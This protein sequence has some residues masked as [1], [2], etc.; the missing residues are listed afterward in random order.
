MHIKPSIRMKW[1]S[2]GSQTE[3]KS[4]WSVMNRRV[5]Q[6][7]KNHKNHLNGFQFF[8]RYFINIW[9]C[10]QSYTFFSHFSR[11]HI[12]HGHIHG[13]K[14]DTC[15]SLTLFMWSHCKHAGMSPVR[16]DSKAEKFDRCLLVTSCNLQQHNNM[17][18]THT[19]PAFLQITKKCIDRWKK[20]WKHDV[21]Y[22]SMLCRNSINASTILTTWWHWY[23]DPFRKVPKNPSY[24][25][26][27]PH[28]RKEM[29]ASDTFSLHH[30]LC[31]PSSLNLESPIER[32]PSF[33]KVNTLQFKTFG[34]HVSN[35]LVFG[36]K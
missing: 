34:T 27:L 25:L 22:N 35:H 19:N 21:E 15:F 8:I 14:R 32:I 5:L 11:I 6:F 13:E 33:R 7:V 3:L 26:S 28:S 31:V 4:I 18:D 10:F 30:F 2:I 16:L 17:R 23:H 9:I 1:K 29:N 20:T 24:S 12:F 36:L